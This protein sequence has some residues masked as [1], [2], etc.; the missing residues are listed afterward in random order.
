M[1]KWIAVAVAAVVL[2]AAGAAASWWL[3]GGEEAP[4][5]ATF[6]G[7]PTTGH[8]VPIATRDL[9]PEPLTVAEVFPAESVASGGVTLQRRG[10]E[11]LTDCAEAVWGSAEAAV[12]GCTQVLRAHYATRDGRISGQFLIFNLADSA[13]ADRL[14]A[15]LRS[16]GFVR[17]APGTP[18]GFDA[19]R[20]RAQAR[21]LGHYVTVSWVAPVGAG[22]RV[23]LTHPQV[24]VDSLG[25]AVQK[26]LVD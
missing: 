3:T 9:D 11:T 26:R 6:R 10:T 7:E 20:S 12:A 8:Y 4:R 18:E 25:F 16:G 2:V 15:A 22:G 23:D 13:A 17:S 14:V 19:S 24:A 5:A 1:R 21:A